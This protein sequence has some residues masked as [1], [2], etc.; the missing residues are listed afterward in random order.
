M[1]VGL[2]VRVRERASLDCVR[3][4]G[5]EKKFFSLRSTLLLRSGYD[6][7]ECVCAFRMVTKVVCAARC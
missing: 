6:A 1:C 5:D 3:N 7:P 2:L 4:V